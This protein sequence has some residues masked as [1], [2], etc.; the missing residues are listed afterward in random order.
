LRTFYPFFQQRREPRTFFAPAR[1]EIVISNHM[2]RAVCVERDYVT[3]F[4]K[5][6]ANAEHLAELLTRV[7][8]HKLSIRMIDDVRDLFRRA[9]RIKT[10]PN[11]SGHD[12]ANIADG[13][14]RHVAHQNA[15]RSTGL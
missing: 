3:H 1:D 9:R 6:I 12:R 11:A 14:L 10:D 15:D 13:P 2:V 4:S 7:D 8:Q 5:L